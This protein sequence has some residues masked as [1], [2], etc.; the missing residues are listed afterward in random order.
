MG[1]NGYVGKD[2]GFEVLMLAIAAV[3]A[4]LPYIDPKIPFK[5]A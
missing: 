2:S 5:A 3:R 1:A 4:G